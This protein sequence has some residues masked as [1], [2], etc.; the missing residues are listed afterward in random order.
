MMLMALT[1]LIPCHAALTDTDAE[2]PLC[3]AVCVLSMVPYQMQAMILHAGAQ[4]AMWT[5]A[6]FAA[7]FHCSPAT[8]CMTGSCGL[9]RS[10]CTKSR[11]GWKSQTPQLCSRRWQQAGH[12]QTGIAG[13]CSP[14]RFGSIRIVVSCQLCWHKAYTRRGVVVVFTTPTNAHGSRRR[15]SVEVISGCG[16]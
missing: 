9:P 14:S 5:T 2:I 6:T 1:L 15:C 7:C 3:A 16:L 11:Q 8:R 10:L 4:T 12:Q 13:G